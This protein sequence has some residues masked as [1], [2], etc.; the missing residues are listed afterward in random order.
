MFD[1]F[2]Q[3]LFSIFPLIRYKGPHNDYHEVTL[4][5]Q[6]NYVVDILNSLLCYV[7]PMDS[8]PVEVGMQSF[9]TGALILVRYSIIRFP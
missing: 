9:A 5:M 6:L 8:S 1:F 7:V 3:P 2:C 4:I